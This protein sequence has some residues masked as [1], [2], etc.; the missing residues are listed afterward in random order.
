MSERDKRIIRCGTH[1]EVERA[2][3]CQHLVH[4]REGP[5]GFVEAEPEPDDDDPLAWCLACAEVLEREGEW[6][7][8]AEAQV[9]LSVVCEFCFAALRQQ[10]GGV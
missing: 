7:E 1:G 10:H 2:F 8:V 5:I 9:H 6:T 4:S 3:V